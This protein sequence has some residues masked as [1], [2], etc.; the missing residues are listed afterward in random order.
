MFYDLS[1][2]YEYIKTFCFFDECDKLVIQIN[3]SFHFKLI[4]LFLIKK[5]N[6]LLCVCAQREKKTCKYC[7]KKVEH[8]NSI[9]KKKKFPTINND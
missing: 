6:K 9:R 2:L 7:G 5:R 3:I 1:F 8:K 4:K